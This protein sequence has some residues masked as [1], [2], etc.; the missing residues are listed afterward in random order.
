MTQ[1]GDLGV[2]V[3]LTKIA[4]ARDRL[5]MMDRVGCLLLLRSP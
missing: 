3:V 2:R 5:P 1:Y 4:A